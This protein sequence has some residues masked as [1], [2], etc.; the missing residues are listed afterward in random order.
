VTILVQ[1]VNDPPNSS[2]ARAN[3]DRLW[4]PNHKMV[5]VEIA[6]VTDPENN[7]VVITITK[8]T[9]DEPA[10]GLGDGDT[11]PDAV[12]QGDKVLLRA[13][14]AGTGNGR[15]YQITFRA[16]DGD[17]GTCTGSVSVCVPQSYKDTSCQDDGQVFDSEQ[18]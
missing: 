18:P 13:E 15:V 9:Q 16:D 14:R 2:H 3:P 12:I 11:S 5:P 8:V 7:N 10:N 4:P 6:G 1:D 17:G